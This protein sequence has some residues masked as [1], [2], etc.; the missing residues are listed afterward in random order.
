[1][2]AAAHHSGNA[3]NSKETKSKLK[4]VQKT[5][6]MTVDVKSIQG[7]RGEREIEDLLKYI[8]DGGGKN[9]KNHP[10]NGI[11]SNNQA[12]DHLLSSEEK[13]KKMAAKSNKVNKLKK[14]NSM[15][16]LCS[17]GRQQQQQQE[18]STTAANKIIEDVALRSKSSNLTSGAKKGDKNEKSQQKRNERRSWGTEGLWPETATAVVEPEDNQEI[19]TSSSSSSSGITAEVIPD[20]SAVV[21]SEPVNMVVSETEFHVVMKKRKVKRKQSETSELSKATGSLNNYKRDGNVRPGTR[22]YNDRDVGAKNARNTKPLNQDVKTPPSKNRRKSTSSMPPS[23]DDWN[24]DGGDSVQSLPIETTKTTSSQLLAATVAAHETT[25]STSSSNDRK[26]K[27]Q[28]QKPATFSYADIAKTNANRNNVSTSTEKWPSISASSSS[29]TSHQNNDPFSIANFEAVNNSSSN[30]KT[31]KVAPVTTSMMSFPELVETNNNKNKQL[32][33]NPSAS[34]LLENTSNGETIYTTEKPLNGLEA[35]RAFDSNNNSNVAA[36]ERQK[37]SYSQSLLESHFT[38]PELDSNGNNV[39]VDAASTNGPV[40]KAVLTKSKSVDHNNLSSIEHYPALEKTHATLG[41]VFSTRPAVTFE[42]HASKSKQNMKEDRKQMKKD[43]LKKSS[44]MQNPQFPH[45][46]AILNCRPAVIILNDSTK[47]SDAD[48]GITFGFDI[49]EHLLFG[50]QNGEDASEDVC[51]T[52]VSLATTNNNNNCDITNTNLSSNYLT[53]QPCGLEIYENF[54]APQNII[55][56]DGHIMAMTM[57]SQSSPK[58]QLQLQNA[59]DTSNQS[60]NDMGY[61]SSS[62][63]TNSTSPANNDEQTNDAIMLDVA[64]SQT[65]QM[66]FKRSAA[67]EGYELKLPRF[68]M[69]DPIKFNNEEVVSYIIDGESRLSGYCNILLQ[70]RLGRKHGLS[71]RLQPFIET[72]NCFLDNLIP[73]LIPFSISIAEFTKVSRTGN[74]F[75]SQ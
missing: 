71:F 23:D 14:S 9:H 65:D 4:R 69:P 13:K 52:E 15:D 22:T 70:M 54:I 53:N 59:L 21:T 43:K 12:G 34:S 51:V 1:M 33:S 66:E 42:T 72:E 36:D 48:C 11:V 16:E 27:K 45:P 31:P 8:E 74:V 5:N 60:S 55:I 75:S 41:Q 38:L 32:S 39:K 40:P 57:N 47:P 68:I 30:Q 18:K 20:P 6:E 7:Y 24:S 64:D 61:L 73:K 56:G 58:L 19:E 3:A 17:T 10:K 25:Q 63:I 46:N 67:F 35:P 37:I 28:Q 2:I 44:S 62:L 26:N 49:N 29:T 50:H